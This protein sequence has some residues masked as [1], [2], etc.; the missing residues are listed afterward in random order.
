MHNEISTQP[1]ESNTSLGIWAGFGAVVIGILLSAIAI[2][3][4]VPG[5]LFSI[6]GEEPKVFWLLSRA[7][8]IFSFLMLWASLAFGLALTGK[9]AKWFPGTF[10]ANDLHQFISITGLLFG[11]LH[12]ILLT[13][14]RYMQINLV[15]VFLS[16]HCDQLQTW[17]GWVR[18][19]KPHPLGYFD[20][21]LLCT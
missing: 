16:F 7:T 4:W 1:S 9:I 12:G 3:G 6:S 11:I 21:I 17:L 19:T 13:G 8:A 10:T 5:M 20:L 18:S 14:D 2:P 15:Q